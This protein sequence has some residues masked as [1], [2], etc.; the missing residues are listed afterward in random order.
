MNRKCYKV[1]KAN[2][3]MAGLQIDID[4]ARITSG[5]LPYFL[6]FYPSIPTLPRAWK[7]SLLGVDFFV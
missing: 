2:L 7:D 5:G 3:K 6:I 4:S 1:H